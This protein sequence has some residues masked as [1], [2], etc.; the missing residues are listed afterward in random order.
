MR[1]FV[2]VLSLPLCLGLACDNVG[3]L[4]DPSAPTFAKQPSNQIVNAGSNATF[5]VTA[6]GNPTP[7]F[8]WE[9]SEDSG[10]TWHSINGAV[11]SIYICAAQLND[12]VDFQVKASNSRGSITSSTATLTVM[13]TVD[14][15]ANTP[16]SYGAQLMINNRRQRITCLKGISQIPIMCYADH[17]FSRI[18]FQSIV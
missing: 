18:N 8:T 3:G 10:K 9:R 12:N 14:S 11:S 1:H 13:P 15:A 5:T 2:L 6:N 16:G 17:I 7:T 4:H